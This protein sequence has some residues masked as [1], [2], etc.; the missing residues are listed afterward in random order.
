MA[1]DLALSCYPL[2]SELLGL[3]IFRGSRILG[4]HAGQERTV[5][6]LNLSDTP[7]YYK[8]LS[9][10]ELMVTTCYAIR[11]DPRALADYVPNLAAKGISGLCLKPAQ[12]LGEVPQV[13]VDCAN[14]LG[15]ALVELPAD[16]RFS[17]ITKAVS[18]ELLRRQA[19]LLRNTLTVNEMLT[20]TIVEGAG[21]EEIVG[22]VSQLTG[23][24]VLIIDC[25]NDRRAL[26]LTAD[27]ESRFAELSSDAVNGTV[28]A[29]GRMY[30][31]EVG[32]YSFGFL[33]IYDVKHPAAET[34]ED[35]MRQVLQTIPLE[36]SRER[37]VR[38][39]GDQHF[40]DF[41][42]HLLSDRILDEP[43]ELA[44]AESFRLDL[45]QNHLIV[46]ARVADRTA[47][48]NKYVGVFQRTLLSNEIKSTVNNLGLSIR[49]IRTGEEHLILLS[50][51]L[52]NHGFAVVAARF[53]M[54]VEQ[55]VEKY[56]ALHIVA[57]CGR[58][59]AGIAG[60]V[61]SDKEARLAIRVALARDCGLV[62]FDELGLM[63]LIYAGDPDR[64]I[65][66]F[67]REM[68][69][70]LIDPSYPKGAELLSTLERY[71][72]CF[73]NLKRMSEEMFTHYNTMVYRIKCIREITGLDLRI[74]E[75]RFR[76][77]LALHLY[78]L[79]KH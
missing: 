17:A 63:R 32:G 45:S 65:E 23:S 59:Y 46:R 16:L 39:S 22:M 18:D 35:I 58:P 19:T 48:G 36:I 28:I 44:R 2:L 66:E 78:R 33:Y 6:G 3:P 41:L 71:F 15:L 75:E 34:D 47:G 49:I 14:E 50:S 26:S 69:G 10:G 30:V 5:T 64:E 62:R 38:E 43:M 7:E 21:L 52:D 4:G 79:T 54:A 42:L 40:N 8:W 68:L 61:R 12:Y 60:L 13:M 25:I 73:G 31:L 77:E 1:R 53:P 9:A 20:R 70:P 37:R 24:S 67:M 11:N 27:D 76:M 29:E 51:P 56:G 72:Y 74:P 55:F 57:G